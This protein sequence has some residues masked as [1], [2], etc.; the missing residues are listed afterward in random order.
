MGGRGAGRA[1]EPHTP[2]RI[3]SSLFTGSSVNH[4]VWGHQTVML[5][6]R[7]QLLF[8]LRGGIGR[9]LLE[10]VT[11]PR[12]EAVPLTH[13]SPW[14]PHCHVQRP[15]TLG[16]RHPPGRGLRAP[17]R[18]PLRA[19]HPR[20]PGTWRRSPG[21]WCFCIQSPK[22]GHEALENTPHPALHPGHI[23]PGPAAGGPALSLGHGRGP[24]KVRT[25]P[26]TEED[27]V[28]CPTSPCDPAPRGRT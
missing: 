14:H 16:K 8:G 20:C 15:G 12:L 22:E 4:P 3:K 2:C 23:L 26:Q 25:K 17:L 1:Q 24:R 28:S 6:G 27:G 9:G 11:E 7:L 19:A 5:G 21:P 18:A 13:P 10:R